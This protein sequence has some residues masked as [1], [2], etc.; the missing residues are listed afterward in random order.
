MKSSCFKE[1]DVWK[2][3]YGTQEQRQAAIDNA[4]RHFDRLR[5]SASAP[6]WQKL[7]PDEDRNKGISLSRLQSPLAKGHAPPPPK[8]WVSEADNSSSKDNSEMVDDD[9]AKKNRENVA[10]SR[11]GLD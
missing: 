1:L 8:S 9:I 4:I 6:V 11:W 2:Y 7:L 3:D 10:G 5:A